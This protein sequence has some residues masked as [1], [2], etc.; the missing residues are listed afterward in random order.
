METNTVVLCAV[1][2]ASVALLILVFVVYL[3][4]AAKHQSCVCSFSST[5]S[6]DNNVS[7]Q[8][9]DEGSALL[10]PVVLHFE[11]TYG[12]TLDTECAHAS[13]DQAP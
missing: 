7:Q 2:A 11:S 9:V 5:M 4:W 13:I 3:A 8:S 6:S 1:A 12:S 10:T